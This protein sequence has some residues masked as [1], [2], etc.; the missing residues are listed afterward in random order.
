MLAYAVRRTRMCQCVCVQNTRLCWQCHAKWTNPSQFLHFNQS[1]CE[2][3]PVN[4]FEST[5]SILKELIHDTT[6][7]WNS[8]WSWQRFEQCTMELVPNKF[9][10]SFA[11]VIEFARQVKNNTMKFTNI[12]GL[13][14]VSPAIYLIAFSIFDEKLTEIQSNIYLRFWLYTLISSLCRCN[15]QLKNPSC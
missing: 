11:N 2:E 6:S 4:N 9:I 14:D 10:R 15:L 1:G 12:L 7:C 5:N 8:S 3:C 13:P